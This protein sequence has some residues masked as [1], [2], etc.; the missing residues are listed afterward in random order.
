MC[1]N[2]YSH[3]SHKVI[4]RMNVKNRIKVGLKP[5]CHSCQEFSPIMKLLLAFCGLFLAA[6]SISGSSDE[7]LNEGILCATLWG[8][9]YVPSPSFFTRDKLWQ[10]N[11]HDFFL[12]RYQE[13]RLL[14]RRAPRESSTYTG[15]SGYTVSGLLPE[16]M[17]HPCKMPVS[18]M[19]PQV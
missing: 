11:S 16:E 13:G 2:Y 17:Q 9:K 14:R 1:E 8:G 7:H 18:P 5:T 6:N 10:W 15:M 19:L 12:C 3:Y 4:T